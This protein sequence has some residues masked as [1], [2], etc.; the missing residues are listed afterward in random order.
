MTDKPI[1]AID[2]D[3]PGVKPLIF[4]DEMT[5][6]TRTL[7][8]DAGLNVIV[9]GTRA[10]TNGKTVVLPDV[11]DTVNIS[12]N[13]ANVA[14][15]YV[16]HEAAHNRYTD[17]EG[18]WIAKA[19]AHGGDYAEAVLQA[20]EDV[21]IE[22]RQVADY[23]GSKVNLSATANATY[24]VLNEGIEAGEYDLSDQRAMF[25]ASVTARGRQKI[26]HDLL[27]EEVEK[28][29][30]HL[31]GENASKL[32]TLTDEIASLAS[33]EDAFHLMRRFVDED[34]QM[35]DEPL[36]REAEGQMPVKEGND[37][38][39]G[40]GEGG[41]QKGESEG[42]S[43][44]GESAKG[45]GGVM[46]KAASEAV[47]RALGTRREYDG[48]PYLS[49]WE[50]D[51][52][53]S[54]RN[55]EEV[56]KGVG[57]GAKFVSGTVH[58]CFLGAKQNEGRKRY[59]GKKRR[60][61]PHL[62]AIKS[63]FE[64]YLMSKMQRGWEHALEQGLIDPRRLAQVP[65][66]ASNVYRRRDPV[67]ELDTCVSIIVDMSGS[68]SG[69]EIAMAQEA[70]IA[71]SEAMHRLGIPFEIVGH[72]TMGDDCSSVAN[73]I[74]GHEHLNK[75]S[76]YSIDEYEDMPIG[77]G[78]K[79]YGLYDLEKLAQNV[80]GKSL[81]KIRR[82][83]EKIRR[84]EDW[85]PD[86]YADPNV[87]QTLFVTRFWTQNI[88]EF[89]GFDDR[90]FDVEPYI[91]VMDQMAGG[92]TI[93]ADTI[94]KV[95][96]RQLRRKEK[97]RVIVVLSDGQPGGY[98]L[99]DEEERTKDVCRYVESDKN[100]HLMQIGIGS[101]AGKRYYSNVHVINNTNELAPVLFANLKNI[102][103]VQKAS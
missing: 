67:Q 31:D 25:P 87:Y 93:E 8:R 22:G 37:D 46:S 90:L 6:V 41:S 88:Y 33:T 60:I 75:K 99:A 74:R 53:I 96:Q 64:R 65:T 4:K 92:G 39:Q 23:P 36:S 1:D 12:Q 102:L 32:E 35:R 20:I 42:E 58:G 89:K 59:N 62:N 55:V 40:E 86:V 21:R 48:V 16:D 15:G 81:S 56:S 27:A 71:I 98:G 38:G 43:R 76:H 34:G 79:V 73:E 69:R 95:Y 11:D 14:R 57:E 103:R 24:R 29:A 13:A 52:W 66:G 82:K 51:M 54:P 18:D 10:F 30:S 3:A 84:K 101:P 63:A 47:S 50:L 17:M 80:A 70:C 72:T 91:G 28:M 78:P 44:M 2:A 5:R 19:R 61:G 94:L 45:A 7:S 97:K 77:V 9:S 26:G 100:C 49:D 68:M 83:E 85:I